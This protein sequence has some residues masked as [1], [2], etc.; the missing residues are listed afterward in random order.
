MSSSLNYKPSG[1]SVRFPVLNHLVTTE[2]LTRSLAWRVMPSWFLDMVQ[3]AV[4]EVLWFRR[5][6]TRILWLIKLSFQREPWSPTP[7]EEAGSHTRS[8]SHSKAR[9]LA[10][11]FPPPLSPSGNGS[12]SPLCGPLSFPLTDPHLLPFLGGKQASLSSSLSLLILRPWVPINYCN[13]RKVSLK[14]LA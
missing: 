12:S 5:E 6:S 11:L 4:R 8:L 14:S 7:T 3:R 13:R 9:I 10:V 1:F 2:H